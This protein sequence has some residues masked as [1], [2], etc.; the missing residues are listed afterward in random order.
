MRATEA[1]AKVPQVTLLFWVIK[2]A[3]TTLGETGG[4]AVTLSMDLGYLAGTVIFAALFAAVA[5]AQIRARRFHPAL[6]WLTIL[7]TTTVGTTLAD[8]ADR[9][10]GIGY[11]GGTALLAALLAF[12]LI[13][14]R[15]TLGTISVTSITSGRAEAF[16]WLTI[17]FSQTLGTVLGDWTADS[18][19][20]GYAGGMQ[21]FSGLLTLVAAAY[22]WTCLSRSG[23]ACHAPPCSGRPSS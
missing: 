6:Y 7:A 17:L 4:D 18:E 8:F 15:A 13:T 21:V 9:S 2:V 11:A 12:S 19:G 16:Y 3:A 23:P 14:W 20:L 5:T 1:A 10:L 22:F